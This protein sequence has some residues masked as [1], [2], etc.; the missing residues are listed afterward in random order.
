MLTSKGALHCVAGGGD[1]EA[2]ADGVWCGWSRCASYRARASAW[3]P[4]P[5][6]L[7]GAGSSALRAV[8]ASPAGGSP[9]V[10][11]V[12]VRR[13]TASAWRVGRAG[14]ARDLGADGGRRGAMAAVPSASVPARAVTGARSC[15]R[16]GVKGRGAGA[17]LAQRSGAATEGERRR[18]VEGTLSTEPRPVRNAR[19]STSTLAHAHRRCACA[20]AGRRRRRRRPRPCGSVEW[21][22]A[23]RRARRARRRS[24]PRER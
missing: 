10:A 22:A 18:G 5:A 13:R 4:V 15:S 6:M 8:R 9:S 7:Y 2:A 17:S 23:A 1:G 14:R 24:I 16:A 11:A 3:R 19:A 20:S 12:A 21:R